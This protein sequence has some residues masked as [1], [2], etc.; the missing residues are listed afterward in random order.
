MQK[1]RILIV[2][3]NDEL[4]AILEQVLGTLGPRRGR[5][6]RARKRH[7]LGKTWTSLI[8][9]LATSPKSWHTQTPEQ[10]VGELQRKHLLVPVAPNGSEPNVIKAFKMG[11]ANYLRLPYNKDELR[12]IVE[13]TL[14][15]KLALC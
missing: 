1:R 10:A 14:A 13:Q 6:R 3:N 8:S 2:D 11:A 12:E 15:H 5:D 9:L 4:R 7:L